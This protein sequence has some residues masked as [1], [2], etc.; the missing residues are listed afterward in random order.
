MFAQLGTI[1]FENLK[2]F[3]DF[4]KTGSAIYAEHALIDGK[5]RLQRT[6]SSLDEINLS[7]RFHASFCNPKQELNLLIAAK[8]ESQILPLLWGNGDLSGDFV[9]TE[10]NETI[11]HADPQGNVFSYLVSF[12][13]KEYV[14]K[15]KIQQAQTELKNNAKAV[16]EK[17]PIAKKKTNPPTCPQGIS[18]L[19]SQVES[20]GNSVNK[21]MLERGGPS[22]I[23]NKDA[24]KR[25]AN[26]VGL[27]AKEIEARTTNSNSCA[28]NDIP[29][30][31][32]AVNVSSAANNFAIKAKTPGIELTAYILQSD[33]QQLQG[34]I[35]SL[36]TSASSYIN[37]AITRK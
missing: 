9:I 2:T 37:Q 8:D 25:F 20:N 3:N 7:I 19:V 13:L 31:T 1:Q 5:P 21:I 18:K 34:Y 24:L 16:G 36:K 23:E 12:T 10:I 30:R 6:G 26:A 27:Y 17:K 32:W 22:S 4:S 33:N 35:K 15:D 11:E 29:L 14:V 28:W